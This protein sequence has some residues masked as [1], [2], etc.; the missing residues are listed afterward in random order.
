MLSYFLC[1][2]IYYFIACRYVKAYLLPDR[3]KSSKRKTKTKKNTL[4]P[5]FG[6]TLKVGI[7]LQSS[8]SDSEQRESNLIEY[9]FKRFSSR[10]L[11]KNWRDGH[12]GSLSGILIFLGR[13][14]S[15]VRS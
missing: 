12:S 8:I 6:E 11:L 1:N 14:N 13:T 9:F 4:N 2:I 7:Q 10:S 3:T 5:V 15:W